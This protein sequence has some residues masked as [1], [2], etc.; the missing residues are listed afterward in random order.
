MN[1]ARYV[2]AV[3]MV[4]AIPPAVVWWFIVHPF[5]G[6]W[7]R[8]GTKWTFTFLTVFYLA[9]IVGLYVAKDVLVG[10]DYGTSWWL[11]AA[12]V[13]PFVMAVAIGRRR[14]KHLKF[15]TL[16]GLPEVAPDGEGPGLLREGIY[17]RIRHPRYV[18]FILGGI[19]Y[20]LFINYLGVYLMV[21]GA[22]VSILVIVELEERELRQR[23]GE[24]Y[25]EYC[26]QVPRFFP[27]RS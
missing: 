17:S 20:A 4:I 6:F 10:T 26:E 19:G 5:I 8:V 9:S 11:V 25:A 15:R 21:A 12:A 18:E 27:R 7:R 1:T 23:F 22:L 14:R 2:L 13:P 16:A 24:A 3:L